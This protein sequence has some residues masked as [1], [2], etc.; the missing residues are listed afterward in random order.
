MVCTGKER[1]RVEEFLRDGKITLV[2]RSSELRAREE[3][4]G[5]REGER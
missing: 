5:G 3:K 2:A 4:N 1:E